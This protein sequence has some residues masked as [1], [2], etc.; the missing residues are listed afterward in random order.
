MHLGV[1][2]LLKRHYESLFLLTFRFV[3]FEV[4]G[5]KFPNIIDT[6]VLTST[7]FSK[8]DDLSASLDHQAVTGLNIMHRYQIFLRIFRS[9]GYYWVHQGRLSK[10][11]GVSS[12]AAPE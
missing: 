10:S 1:D 4:G 12:L 9:M 8:V 2:I 11:S 5:L 3:V 7:W 6:D